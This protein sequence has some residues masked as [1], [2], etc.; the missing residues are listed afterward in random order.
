MLGKNII[1]GIQPVYEILKYKYEYIYEIYILYDSEKDFK[2]Q[3]LMTLIKKRKIKINFLFRKKIKKVFPKI[4][5]CNHHNRFFSDRILA[6][7][8]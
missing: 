3:F 6:R 8:Y 5:D 2:H 7:C 4:N 1:Y